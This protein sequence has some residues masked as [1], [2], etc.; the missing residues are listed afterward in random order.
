MSAPVRP[1]D[2]VMAMF[3]GIP[4]RLRFRQSVVVLQAVIDD[5]GRGQGPAFILA[6]WIADPGKWANFSDA[7]DTVLHAPP[8]IE[9][10]KMSDA[11]YF[12]KEFLWMDYRSTRQKSC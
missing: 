5:S 6:G 4:S 11:W 9:Y 1:S 2:R 7:W 8:S 12:K 3:S 10:F